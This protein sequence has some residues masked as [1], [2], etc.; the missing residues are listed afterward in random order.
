[1][2]VHHGSEAQQALLRRGAHALL[3]MHRRHGFTG[4]MT[5]VEPGNRASEA[6]CRRMG[7]APRGLSIVGMADPTR[8]PGGRMTK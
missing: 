3:E 7:F 5:G 1:M 2:R 6:I 8:L 4:A